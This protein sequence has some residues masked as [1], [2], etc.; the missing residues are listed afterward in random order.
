MS[1]SLIVSDLDHTL[2][3]AEHGLDAITIETFQAL[4]ARGHHLAIASGRHFRDI[5]AVRQLLGVSGHIISTNGAHLHAPDDSLIFETLVPND[6]V[7]E[8]MSL[9]VPGSVRINLYTGD[10]WLI[11]A[12]APSLLAFH[13]STGFTYE[14]TDVRTYQGGD[15]GK[16]LFIG[17]PE[18]L[19]ALETEIQARLGERVHVTYSLPNSLEV[20][21]YDA[22]KG[23]MLRRLMTR[24]E[25]PP[26][27]TLAFGDNLNDIDMLQ[28]AG[29]AFAV[30]NAHTRLT[31]AA[32]HAEIIGSNVEAGVA[33][34]LREWFALD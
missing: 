21:H 4:A 3:N 19:A 27:R 10:R 17:D 9:D 2:L 15:V 1:A 20:M 26:E 23:R 25:V 7:S 32:P 5:A 29:C 31:L 12:P 14:V 22:S 34:K 8:L 6:V 33:W 11:D 30:A 16:V 24:L 28:T 18:L 13:A